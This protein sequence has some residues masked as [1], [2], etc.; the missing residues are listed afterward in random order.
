MKLFEQSPLA[1]Q[2]FSSRTLA[3]LTFAF[4]G[5][6]YAHRQAHLANAVLMG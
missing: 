6:V 4:G 2:L 5:N 1:P 3:G